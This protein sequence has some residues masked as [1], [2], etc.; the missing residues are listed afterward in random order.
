MAAGIR[1]RTTDCERC[2]VLLRTRH[3]LS[4]SPPAPPGEHYWGG[5]IR[6]A[7]VSSQTRPREN[8]V[9]VANGWCEPLKSCGCCF[10]FCF[11]WHLNTPFRSCQDGTN[12]LACEFRQ[13]AE[14]VY[15]SK[16]EQNKERDFFFVRQDGQSI[17]PRETHTAVN[18]INLGCPVTSHCV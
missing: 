7:P 15:F 5:Q 3:N 10:V 12:P 2:S 17:D 13:L 8:Q 1:Q 16:F 9:W 14:P 6:W 11:F 4:Y 18:L